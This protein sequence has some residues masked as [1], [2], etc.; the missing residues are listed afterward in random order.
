VTEKTTMPP[1]DP[2][3]RTSEGILTQRIERAL[4]PL[5]ALLRDSNIQFIRALLR[6][7]LDAD[8]LLSALVQK[9]TRRT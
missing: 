5:R 1:R 8:P 7:R 3:P 9:L 4:A 6:E 2:L